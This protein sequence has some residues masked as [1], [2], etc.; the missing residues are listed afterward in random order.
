MAFWQWPRIWVETIWH[1]R[2]KMKGGER[3]QAFDHRI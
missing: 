1:N 2:A 3:I